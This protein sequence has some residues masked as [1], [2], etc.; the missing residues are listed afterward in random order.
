MELARIIARGLIEVENTNQPINCRAY[1]MVERSE[2][3]GPA[4]G[5]RFSH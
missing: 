4:I 1:T 3:I 5:Y 2:D